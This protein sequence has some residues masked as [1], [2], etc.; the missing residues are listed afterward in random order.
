MS[1]DN[2]YDRICKDRFNTLERHVAEVD[3]KTDSIDRVVNNGLKEGVQE[4]RTRFKFVI[5]LEVTIIVG[6]G[7]IIT[8]LLL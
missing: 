8:A 1:T 4:L 3:K 7:G 2:N 6:L 5:G